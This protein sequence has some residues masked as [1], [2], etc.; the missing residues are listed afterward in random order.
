M[1]KA[2]N[3]MK[4]GEAADLDDVPVEVWKKIE[5]RGMELLTKLFNMMLAC[6]NTPEEWN[7]SIL[8]PIFKDKGDMQCYSSYRE[9]KLMIHIMRI[10]KRRV[11]ARLREEVMICEQKYGFMPRKSSTDPRFAVTMLMEKNREG[12]KRVTLCLCGS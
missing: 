8:V 5:E 10:W 2:L 6:E 11:E 3:R 7:K 12:Q 1:N 4:N 9:I